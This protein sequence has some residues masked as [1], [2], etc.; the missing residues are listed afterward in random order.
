[1]S[2]PDYTTWYGGKRPVP[3]ET[4]VDVIIYRDVLSGYPAGLFNWYHGLGHKQGIYHYRLH[5]AT[6]AK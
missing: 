1:M 2:E 3:A 5:E 6:N 4:L